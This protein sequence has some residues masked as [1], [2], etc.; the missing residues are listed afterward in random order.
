[1]YTPLYECVTHGCEWLSTALLPAVTA[2]SIH[3]KCK[4][5]KCSSSFPLTSPP[6]SSCLTILIISLVEQSNVIPIDDS[7][8]KKEWGVLLQ[9]LRFSAV[10][11]SELVPL[12]VF[13]LQHHLGK[14][15]RIYT[16][17]KNLY[18]RL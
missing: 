7:V 13:V 2:S 10:P 1:M 9:S 17:K 12:L 11:T 14:E 16:C 8:P 18:Q 4:K 3:P 15:N 6:F 5:K